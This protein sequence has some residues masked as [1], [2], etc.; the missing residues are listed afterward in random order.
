MAEKVTLDDVVEVLARNA[1]T[2]VSPDDADVLNRFNQQ[3][4][5]EQ[6]A[7]S[8]PAKPATTGKDK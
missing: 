8:Q 1:T 7:A 4:A 2:P 5:D 6:A 3:V